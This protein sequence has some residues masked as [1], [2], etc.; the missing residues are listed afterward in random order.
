[1]N[2][3]PVPTKQ[4]I[5]IHEVQSVGKHESTDVFSHS[6]SVREGHTRFPLLEHAD[7]L[8]GVEMVQGSHKVR[9]TTGVFWLCL[10][11]P[12]QLA[13]LAPPG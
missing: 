8:L 10:Q 6:F 9:Q 13:R 5:K 2:V 4:K 3:A 7:G 1:M 12:L 11:R